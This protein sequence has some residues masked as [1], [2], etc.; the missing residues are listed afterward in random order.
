MKKQKVSIMCLVLLVAICIIPT[1]ARA[2]ELI[3]KT[4]TV[5]IDEV[6]IELMKTADNFIILGDTSFS[7]GERYKKTGKDKIT[8]QK[9]ILKSRN[10]ALPDLG[11]NG[12]LY[13][14]ATE[15]L[16]LAA[17]TVLKPYYEVKPYNRTEFLKAIDQLPTKAAG[18]TP[19]QG[20]LIELDKVL[21][22]LKGHT[23][24][25]LVTDGSYSKSYLME[26]PIEI[27]RDLAQKYDVS[28]Y[29]IDSSGKEKNQQFEYLVN[30]INAR[31]R[32]IS[33]D[34]FIENPLF[35]SGALF[36]LDARIVKKSI[37]VEKVIGIK[38]SNLLFAFDSAEINTKY[39]DSL[40]KLG[41]YMKDTPKARL[42]LSAFTDNK[43]PSSYNLDLSRR[44]VESVASYLEKN[45]KI[46]RTRMVLNYYGEANPVASN[47]TDEGQAKNRRIEGFIFGL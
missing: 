27:A 11:F 36:V 19:L 1:G 46:A 9:E 5:T 43:G 41:K 28:F 40:K 39:A 8:L 23:V 30:S 24:V 7:M 10:E 21:A 35:L 29:V 37:D 13:T 45:Y 18:M 12:G 20:A 16:N 6:R 44:R 22:P 2:F 38:F 26:K 3:T 31:S 25:F 42:G 32:M 34:Q 47:D 14:F 4:E 17:S 33:Y 15:E